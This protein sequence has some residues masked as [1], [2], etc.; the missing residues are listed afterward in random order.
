[1]DPVTLL[2]YDGDGKPLKTDLIFR[3]VYPVPGNDGEL[4]RHYVH[5]CSGKSLYYSGP[6]QYWT[7]D[8][9]N[10]RFIEIDAAVAQD[11]FYE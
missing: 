7:F 4:I 8:S 5:R 11:E 2:L 9:T 1:M 6:G 3:G 10:Q